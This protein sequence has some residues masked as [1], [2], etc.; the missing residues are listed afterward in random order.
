LSSN[1]TFF[2]AH[3]TPAAMSASDI[4]FS[5]W[6]ALRQALRAS[7]LTCGSLRNSPREAPQAEKLSSSASHMKSSLSHLLPTFVGFGIGCS[8]HA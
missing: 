2:V 5:R 6:L 3:L 1:G 7:K 8:R 4:L